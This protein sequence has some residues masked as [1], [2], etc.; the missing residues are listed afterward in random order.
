[1]KNILLCLAILLANITYAQNDTTQKDI[2]Y[3]GL[4]WEITG[5]GLEKPSYLYGTMHVSRKIAFNLDDIFFEALNQADMVAVE[6]MPDNWLDDLFKRGEIGYGGSMGRSNYYGGGNNGGFYSS[7]FNM[8]F[9]NKNDIIT[10]MFGQYNLINGLL[11]RSEGMADFEE[12]TYLDMF[13]YQTGKRFNKGT[14]SLE[15]SE[16]SRDLVEKAMTD[17]RKK[18]VDEWLKDMIEKKNTRMFDILQDAYRDRNIGLIDSLNRAMYTNHYMEHMLF[19]RNENMVDSMETLMKSGSLFAGVG[20][21]HLPGDDGMIDMLLKRGYSLKPIFSGQTDKGKQ[22]KA[23]FENN[24][25]AKTYSPQTTEDGFITLNAPNKLYELYADGG[26]FVVAPDFDNGSYITIARLYSYNSLRERSEQLTEKDLEKLLFEFIPGDIITKKVL[27]SP[28]PGFDIKNETKT[29]NHQRYLFY[30]TP[31]EIIIIKMDGKKEFVKRESDKIFSSLKLNIKD[32]VTVNSAFNSFEVEMPGYTITNNTK[33]R[34]KRFVQAYNDD[35]NSYAFLMENDLNDVNY[36]EEDS[37]ELAYIMEQ[38][39]E[40]LETKLD[41]NG[42][43]EDGKVPA[44]YSY[45]ILDSTEDKRLYLNTQLLGA[46]Y[47]LMGYVGEEK[48]A[49]DFFKTVKITQ[50]SNYTQDFEEQVDTN[51]FFTVHAPDNSGYSNYYSPYY[52]NNNED[53]KEYESYTKNQTYA[54]KSNEEIYIKLN[55]FHDWFTEDHIDSLWID[56]ERSFE[57]EDFKLSNTKKSTIDSTH[58]FEGLL[59]KEKSHRAIKFKYIQKDG[60][61]YSLSTLIH[62]GVDLSPFVDTFFQTFTPKDTIL[63]ISPFVDKSEMYFTAIE[64][65]D[66]ILLDSRTYVEFDDK[67]YEKAKT[68]FLEGE[69]DDDW[70]FIKDILLTEICAMD[71]EKTLPFL[72]KLYIDSYENSDYQ[73][74]ILRR[75]IREQSK[76]SAAKV[77]SLMEQDLPINDEGGRFLW[78]L[79]DSAKIAN[80]LMPKL[81]EYAS[82]PDYKYDIQDIIARLVTHEGLNPKKYKKFKKQYLNEARIELKRAIGKQSQ[83]KENDSYYRSYSGTRS[84]NR[85]VELLYPFKKD[86]KIKTFLD[87]VAKLENAEVQYNFIRLQLI[88]ELPVDKEAVIKLAEDEKER[89]GIYSLLRKYEAL[90]LIPDSLKSKVVLAQGFLSNDNYYGDEIDTIY[91]IKTETVKISGVD[92]EVLYFYKKTTRE[93]SYYEEDKEKETILALAWKPED[94]INSYNYYDI[95]QLKE[96]DETIEDVI[97]DLRKQIQLRDRRRISSYGS[98]YGYETAEETF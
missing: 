70:K 61:L 35:K 93:N 38:F 66:S 60:C 15:S 45:T 89:F 36:I 62:K 41:E 29:G 26:S 20:A 50:F 24:F 69:Y 37:F 17:A 98:S 4:L 16:E 97:K 42:R 92:H 58:Y 55:K 18:E 3:E 88:N 28:Y 65:Q 6:S 11:Y 52:R 63:G 77:L 73:V 64:N 91:H 12:D 34:G 96:D 39:C 67:H 30:V 10:G 49:N 40:N 21:A 54:T 85:Y 79:T 33:Y 25:I 44:F 22:L 95:S 80:P 59:T 94:D 43:Y 2:K 76:T 56:K 81:L 84:L 7:A 83:T 90:D 23:K 5:N 74:Q 71:Y 8:N 13:I 68:L 57:E 51:L 1:M 27:T 82:I 14:F 46:R 86:A 87:D 72:T 53:E 31:I 78:N 32:K 75:L 48:A 19:K 47:Y 9:P